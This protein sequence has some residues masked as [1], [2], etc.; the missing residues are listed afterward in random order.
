MQVKAGAGGEG[1]KTDAAASTAGAEGKTVRKH[2]IVC[3]LIGFCHPSSIPLSPV[4]LSPPLS[5]YLL[6]A[7]VAISRSV[8][9]LCSSIFFVIDLSSGGCRVS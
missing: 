1:K 5:L 8:I 6:I 4:S 9:L 2:H 3:Q 7:F